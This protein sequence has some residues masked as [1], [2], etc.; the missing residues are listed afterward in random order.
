[1][2]QSSNLIVPNVFVAPLIHGRSMPMAQDGW[3]HWLWNSKCDCPG[4]HLVPDC[5]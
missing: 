2:N 4:P 3:L 1:M 5:S